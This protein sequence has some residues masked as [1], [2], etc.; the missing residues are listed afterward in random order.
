MPIAPLPTPPNGQ[1]G[2]LNG[3]SSTDTNK[4]P[5]KTEK[6]TTVIAGATVGSVVAI[7]IVGGA[8]YFLVR[9][10]RTP[11]RKRRMK[12]IELDSHQLEELSDSQRYEIYERRYWELPAPP[13]IPKLKISEVGVEDQCWEMPVPPPIPKPGKSQAGVEDQC[14]EMPASPAITKMRLP[15]PR[16]DGWI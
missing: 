2:S 15:L 14:W 10:R 11:D 13:P 4:G 6:T 5:G 9:L 7:A 12:L 1:S 8:V 16:A 3:S